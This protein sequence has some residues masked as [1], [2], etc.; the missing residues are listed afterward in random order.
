M[1]SMISVV[2]TEDHF[3]LGLIKSIHFSQR[4]ALKT[5]FTFSF[6]VSLTFDFQLLISRVI[7]SQPNLQFMWLFVFANEVG[8]ITSSNV[9][10][11][12]YTHI[13]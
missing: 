11:V 2:W 7:I 6:P 13:F 1:Y 8:I 10:R 5:T 4:N 3:G 12:L 9:R